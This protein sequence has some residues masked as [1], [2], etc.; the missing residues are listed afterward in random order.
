MRALVG[1]KPTVGLLSRHGIIPI[2]HTQDTAGPMTRTVRDAA[3]LLTA[4]A[5]VDANDAGH[6][7]VGSAREAR[8]HGL[9]G[10][11]WP[12]GRADRLPRKK[13]FGYSPW[14]DR[15]AEQAIDVL[16]KAGA[17]IV[18]P[19]DIPTMDEFGTDKPGGDGEFEVLLYEFKAGSEQVPRG[20]RAERA[21]QDA[22]GSHRLQR[23]AQGS[24]DAAIR[25]GDVRDG[26]EEGAADRRE[27]PDGAQELPAALADARHRRRDDAAQAGR[28]R[29]P[30]R[31]TSLGHRL[32]NG[33]HFVGGSSTLPA[34][35]GY[36]HITVP[37][38]FAFELPVGLSFIGRAWSEPT[39]FKLAYAFEQAT[40]ARRPPRF[41]R[42]GAAERL[43]RR[44][45]RGES[46]HGDA[47]NTENFRGVDA[48][49]RADWR[50]DLHQ[51]DTR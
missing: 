19:A 14:S 27:V 10:R 12:Q 47:E 36:P 7:G 1:V 46:R 38:G 17:V 37:A 3:I 16:K 25:P 41:L 30:D 28:A 2:S 29:L 9:P 39:L 49:C 24:R 21:G 11:G 51:R 33:D 42:D 20:A 22:E 40:K 45:D 31:L 4:M 48:A 34:V 13:L 44:G 6:G 23:G 32:V 15:I 50:L 5:G 43:V 35:A 26:R 18:D 8:L